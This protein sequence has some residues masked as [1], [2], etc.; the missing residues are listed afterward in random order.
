MSTEMQMPFALTPSGGVQATTDPNAQ[1]EQHVTALVSTTPGERA[2]LP[3]Y[4]VDLSGRVFDN[5]DQVI[6]TAIGQE[7]QEKMTQFEPN[8]VVTNTQPLMS[9]TGEGFVSVNVEYAVG[10]G[11]TSAQQQQVATVLLGG[12]VITS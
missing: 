3:T 9:D 7:V 11:P 4:G 10:I 12:T 8:I 1:A 2:M 6:A 5:D